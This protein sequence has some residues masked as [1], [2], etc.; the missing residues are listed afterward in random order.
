MNKRRNLISTLVGLATIAL[1]FILS[2]LS[3][4]QPTPPLHWF[5]FTLL[6]S[7]T[8][9]YGIP[10]PIGEVSL[11][12]MVAMISMLVLGIYPTTVIV[13]ISD[14]IYGL[15]RWILPEKAGW[16]SSDDSFNLVATTAANLTMH[17][18]SVIASGLVFYGFDGNVPT[19]SP[20]D[21]II[22]ITSAAAYLV[23]NYLSAA[24]F[25]L[26]RSRPHL[27]SLIE[28]LQT[29]L[30]YEA[31]PLI[32]APL[33]ASIWVMIG[34]VPFMVFAL[35]LVIISVILKNQATNKNVLVRHLK[36]LESLQ[37]VGR[38]LSAILDEDQIA[39]AIYRE[40]S[41]LMPTDNFYLALYYPESDTIHFPINYEH[42]VPLPP[43]SRKFSS[44]LTE[45][46]LRTKEPLLIEKNVKQYVESLGLT[47]YGQEAL[48]W[49]GVPLVAGEQILGMIAVQSYPI[50]NA[51][52]A[53]LDHLHQEILSMIGAQ[54]SIA[55]QNARLYTQ[56]DQAL[57]RRIQELNSILNTTSEG[58]A[59]VND[60]QILLEINQALCGMLGCYQKEILGKSVMDEEITGKLQIDP[61][62]KARILANE[63]ETYQDKVTLTGPIHIPA[64]RTITPVR[65]SED[66][67]DGW[68]LVF[69][70]LT[71]E[72]QLN[73]FREDL[74]RMLVHDLRSPVVSIQ[75]G[76]DMIEVMIDD[77]SKAD[78]MEMVNISRKGSV[79]I[80]EMINEILHLNRLETGKMVLQLEPVDLKTIFTQ[81]ITFLHPIIQQT[82]IKVEEYFERSLPIIQADSGLIKRVVHNLID[83]AIKF[84]PDNGTLTL[85]VKTD[86]ADDGQIILGVQDTGPG[87]PP[88]QLSNLFTK[89][90]TT[91]GQKSRRRG[92][93]LGLY[94]SKLAVAAHGGEIW[95]ESGLGQGTNL[96]IRLPIE[97]HEGSI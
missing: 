9:S 93:G 19:Q 2:K 69:R 91:N 27:Q 73:E 16:H 11:G 26:M 29:L 41:K 25:L 87:I 24:L 18:L 53:K 83:N 57:A 5:I 94:F 80:L 63:L 78:L 49:L 35:S 43:R 54:A 61:D 40:V 17:T 45:Y 59:L 71:K 38:L 6:L 31:I 1:V 81:E 37:V 30:L 89:H 33:A 34:I 23:T 13:V 79:Q 4:S 82:G 74:T 10:L 85:V 72:Q 28:H 15:Y 68:L 7:Y 20:R 62:I 75:G 14:I 48:S 64:E 47:H 84:T 52:P 58:I 77:G 32:F 60:S 12:P 56:T 70:D 55:L 51:M 42:N 90:F 76:L 86:P 36:E 39:E 65:V 44:G 92:T 67:I 66:H 22:L 95:A 96:L 21:V 97:P 88:D 8:S 50:A 46:V 3:D